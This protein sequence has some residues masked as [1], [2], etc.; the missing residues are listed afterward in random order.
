MD[1]NEARDR[2]RKLLASTGMDPD[3]A[4]KVA[5]STP[6]RVLKT[7][8]RGAELQAS[9]MQIDL[10]GLLGEN[11]I[12]GHLPGC[13][14][15]HGRGRGLPNVAIELSEPDDD[16]LDHIGPHGMANVAVILKAAMTYLAFEGVEGFRRFMHQMEDEAAAAGG[17]I[18]PDN[19]VSDVL[20]SRMLAMIG[21]GIRNPHPDCPELSGG[22][23]PDA[24]PASVP[25][26][27][28][29]PRFT[30]GRNGTSD[31]GEPVIDP[32]QFGFRSPLK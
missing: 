9:R 6:E 22:N 4:A 25:E 5:E 20:S 17:A 24:G 21:A 29:K 30:A 28:R 26:A 16:S 7:I 23:C 13:D 12:P 1:E 18:D 19:R 8:M 14:G 3:D 10:D 15:N 2:V 11:H 27:F 31:A 32:R